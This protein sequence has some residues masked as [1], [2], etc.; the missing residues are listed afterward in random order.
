MK[1]ILTK[2]VKGRGKINDLIE[3]PA[4]FGNYLLKNGSAIEGTPENI[5]QL[6]ANKIKEQKAAEKHL[7]DMQKLKE[8][9]EAMKVEVAVKV[10][11]NGKMFGTVSTKEVVE[12]FKAQNGIELDKRKIQYEG[13]IDALGTYKLPIELH[14]EVTANINLYVVE[15]GQK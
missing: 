10:G 2:D 14:K 13:A 1:V 12:A 4:G 5:K 6:E 9:I 8:Q 3:V 11:A 15:A 7:R